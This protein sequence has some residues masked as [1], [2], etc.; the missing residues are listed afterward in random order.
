MKWFVTGIAIA[1]GI[2]LFGMSGE[3]FGIESSSSS[4]AGD[5]DGKGAIPGNGG[6]GDCKPCGC[7]PS[8]QS[9]IDRTNL[10]PLAPPVPGRRS[11]LRSVAF[12]SAPSTPYHIDPLSGQ[13]VSA[14]HSTAL[15]NATLAGNQYVDPLTGLI[16]SH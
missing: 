1:F 16:S 3:A 4:G 14:G 8:A 7:Q 10:T 11:V 13:I 15:G 5:G 9:L 12:P 6:L 2:L